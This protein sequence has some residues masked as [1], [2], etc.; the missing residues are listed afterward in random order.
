MAEVELPVI[1]TGISHTDHESFVAG[2]L[3]GQGWS[4]VYRALDF[5]SLQQ[6]ITSQPEIAKNALLLFSP[7]LLGAT[8]EGIDEIT[9]S[10]RQ[11]VGFHDTTDAS[12][13]YV[14]LYTFPTSAQELISMVRG[15]IR[16]PLIRATP[17]KQSK[18]KRARILAIGS[19]GTATG[20][21]TVALNL[22]ME[23]SLLDKKT[24]LIDANFEAPAIASLLALR[25]INEG[26]T[27]RTIAPNLHA[28]ELSQ[29]T[30]LDIHQ[31]L[32]GASEEF[33]FIIIDLGAAG[34]IAQKMTDRRWQSQA[35]TWAAECADTFLF[36][37]RTDLLGRTRLEELIDEL[38]Q[39]S[40]SAHPT[41]LLNG[42]SPSRKGDSEEASF[43]SIISDLGQR[44]TF[45]LPKD[46]RA[47]ENS[48]AERATLAEVSERSSLRKGLASIAAQLAS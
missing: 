10:L 46:L 41:F 13:E 20:A 12:S 23:L 16:A 15:F 18:N 22:A 42:K 31:L 9:P 38:K 27:W 36:V 48:L 11:V 6:F 19:A 21:T 5:H 26:H 8:A 44:A 37:A 35:M 24:L 40:L 39:T 43:Q 7:D 28:G 47:I 33:D 17:N 45:T 25:S 32:H 34:R 29:E 4:V 3:F 2:T 30:T 14:G 1:I